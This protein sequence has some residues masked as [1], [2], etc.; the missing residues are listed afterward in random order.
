MLGI[1]VFAA[2]FLFVFSITMIFPNVPPGQMVV[3]VFRNFETNYMLA[4]VSGE[5]LIASII[6]GLVWGTI[7]LIIYS[8][9]RGP[10]KRKT[11]LPVW[12]PGHATARS[13]K[14]GA[15]INT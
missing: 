1:L 4:G 12:V 7:I 3:D 13:S 2:S 6:N 10:Q 14:N 8:Y 9:C 15:Y 5:L 11:T